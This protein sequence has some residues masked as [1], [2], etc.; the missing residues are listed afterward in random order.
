VASWVGI[1]GV[2][3]GDLIQAGTDETVG[4]SGP[5][6]YEAWY[7][8]LPR[9]SQ[10]VALT[11]A[12]GDRVS[13]AITQPAAGSWQI[14]IADTTTGQSS[15]QTVSYGSSLGSAEW[16]VE[17][18]SSR[19]RVLPLA[20]FGTIGFS[21]A[22]TVQNG[23]SETIAQA[24]GAAVTMSGARG[25]VEAAPSSLGGDGESFSVTW[26]AAGPAAPSRGARRPRGR[27]PVTGGR[28][29]RRGSAGGAGFGPLGLPASRSILEF[30]IQSITHR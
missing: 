27:F 21:G 6:R 25:Q 17:A 13:V 18:P 8:L 26:S 9:A 30:F 1:G 4:A 24:D 14:Q 11:I 5:A 10:P 16:I 28:G 23:A 2:S 3:S 12:P 15:N 20:D 19:R 7:E 29:S 22:T